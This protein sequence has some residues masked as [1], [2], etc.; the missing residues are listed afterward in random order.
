MEK[1]FNDD[2][3]ADIMNEIES[4]EQEFEEEVH[5]ATQ[6]VHEEPVVAQE[7]PSDDTEQEGAFKPEEMNAVLE[8]LAEMSEEESV[9]EAS[10]PQPEPVQAKEVAP[11]V[12]SFPQPQSQG[13]AQTSMNF[14]VSGDLNLDLNFHFGQEQVHIWVSEQEGFVIEMSSGAKFT[15]PVSASQKKA[16]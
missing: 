9:P 15:I 8:D 3:L 1:G 2:E 5:Q 7:Q 11:N 14:Q 16:A 13:S 12:H 10:Q 6:E 4:L